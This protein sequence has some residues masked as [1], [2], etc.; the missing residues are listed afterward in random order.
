M[1]S[2]RG[3]NPNE[4]S[5]WVSGHVQFTH[6]YGLAMA[7]VNTVNDSQPNFL[8]GDVPMSENSVVSL[9]RPQLYYTDGLSGYAVVGAN[10]DEVD[11]AVSGGNDVVSRYEGEGGVGMGSF[12]RRA[13]FA[14]RFG[15]F[16]PLFSGQITDESRVIFHRDVAERVDEIAPFVEWDA[17]PYPVVLEGRVVYIIDGYT[18]SDRYPYSQRAVVSDLDFGSELN[19][20]LNYVRNSVKAVVD[21][22]DGSVDL[23]ITHADDPIIQAWASAF[24]GLFQQFDEFPEGLLDHVRYPEDLFRVQSNHYGRYRIIDE[25]EFFDR[26][27]EWSVSPDPGT[28]EGEAASNTVIDPVTGLPISIAEER[29]A[30]SYQYLRLPD[31]DEEEFVISRAFVPRSVDDSRQELEAVMYGSIDRDSFGELRVLEI[32]DE[33]DGPAL[34][35]KTIQNLQEISSDQSLL[36]QGTSD[37]LFGEF[38]LIPIGDT[39]VYARPF[40]VRTSGDG[41]PAALTNVIVV[42]G[43]TVGY[44][45][46]FQGALEEATGIDLSRVFGEDVGAPTADEVATGTGDAVDADDSDS[47]RDALT[48]IATEEAK[49][50]EALSADPIDWEAFGQAQAAIDRLLEELAT[51]FEVDATAASPGVATTTTVVG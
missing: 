49:K 40:Y 11:Y 30:P 35:D 50:A 34:A 23:Y 13:A 37:A 48:R 38:Q 26:A 47:V 8:V 43:D 42:V 39:V 45:P 44:E 17:D 9:D 46:T 41:T 10:T 33:V 4:L 1:L 32:E 29:I 14:L 20:N 5:S 12:I 36:D 19:R 31:A 6:G 15:E 25:G 16:E 27:S 22:Y 28:G 21:T 51:A 18:T 7:S 2:A 24:P 3:L